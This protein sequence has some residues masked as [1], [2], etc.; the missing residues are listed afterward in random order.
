MHHLETCLLIDSSRVECRLILLCF[1][2]V[3]KLDLRNE[4]HLLSRIFCNL[5]L[6]CFGGFGS[7]N[8]P[9]D[10]KVFGNPPFQK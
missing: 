2:R 8:A 10:K 6:A 9:L 7:R 5:W 3:F 4:I 1:N